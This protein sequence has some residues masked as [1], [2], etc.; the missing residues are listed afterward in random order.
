MKTSCTNK[1]SQQ[2]KHL[3]ALFV[4]REAFKHNLALAKEVAPITIAMVK[5]DAYGYGA[6]LLVNDD[7]GADFWAVARI[8]EAS[9]LPATSKPIIISS[10]PVH[11]MDVE[12]ASQQG[13]QLVIHNHTQVEWLKEHKAPIAVW[14]KFNVGMHRLGFGLNEADDVI[15]VI[16]AM[17]H[18]QIIGFWGHLPC[19]SLQNDKHSLG[20]AKAYKQALSKFS[21]FKAIAN[22]AAILRY[23]DLGF[24]ATRPG[25]MLYGVSPFSWNFDTSNLKVVG[26]LVAQ[27]IGLQT[28]GPGEGVSY[29]FIW[30]NDSKQTKQVAVI[31]IGYGDGFP[32]EVDHTA[33]V[34][35]NGHEHPIIGRVC[36]DMLM[37]ETMG[38]NLAIGDEAILWGQGLP[39]EQVAASANT[40]AYTLSA[41]LTNRVTR[42]VE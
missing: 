5:A 35:I 33:K 30:N 22:S 40:I 25:I 29:D 6:K 3:P 41:Q 12:I 16:Q 20:A 31:N 39:I 36:M 4:S 7:T 17:G 8:N 27:V 2:N 37:V 26:T 14:L 13:F 19:S 21:G 32:R 42:T 18:V 28:V 24:D 9:E 38:R 23:P 1:A 34:L 11:P 10:G 15:K